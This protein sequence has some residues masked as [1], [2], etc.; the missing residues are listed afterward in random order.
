[1]LTIVVGQRFGDDWPRHPAY[2]FRRSRVNQPDDDP[3]DA[4]HEDIA[5]ERN[6]Q[7]KTTPR[8]VPISKPSAC[9]YA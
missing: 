4:S 9:G 6:E 3:G 8:L 5:G 1:L 7:Q 2:R